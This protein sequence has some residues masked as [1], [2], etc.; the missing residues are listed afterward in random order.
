MVALVSDKGTA[1][2]DNSNE[3]KASPK[4]GIEKKLEIPSTEETQK[5]YFMAFA[6]VF[7]GV[8][9]KGQRLYVLGPRH[10]PEEID[11]DELKDELKNSQANRF[12][13]T[14]SPH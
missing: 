9:R 7:S 10:E 11:G 2:V 5:N 6:R 3:C 14:A 4:T 8:M 1:D 13:L 12:V